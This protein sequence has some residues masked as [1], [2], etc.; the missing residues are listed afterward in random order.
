M[1]KIR[2][3]ESESPLKVVDPVEVIVEPLREPAEFQVE[4]ENH[5]NNSESSDSGFSEICATD[6]DKS[7]DGGEIVKIEI[8]TTETTHMAYICKDDKTMKKVQRTPS[9]REPNN[10]IDG[11]WRYKPN[12]SIETEV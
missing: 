9:A 2:D 7:E 12:N 5:I 1:D 4:V 8:V 11:H 10:I 3:K 6:G